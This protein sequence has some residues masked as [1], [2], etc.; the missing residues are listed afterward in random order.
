MSNNRVRTT[1]SVDKE[2]LD[3]FRAM[4]ES[5]GMSLGRCIG[6]WLEDTAD[7]AQMITNKLT[8]TRGVPSLFLRSISELI[9]DQ[10]IKIERA[11]DMLRSANYP[12]YSNTGVNSPEKG[13]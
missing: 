7:A 13:E 5:S 1:I 11:E 8:E 9:D 2:V 6:Y 3:T 10:K 12:P 4:A